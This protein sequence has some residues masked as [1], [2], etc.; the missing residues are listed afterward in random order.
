MAKNALTYY[1]YY[2]CI[3]S[4]KLMYYV[5]NSIIVILYSNTYAIKIVHNIFEKEDHEVILSPY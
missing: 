1:Q 4:V 5:T 3:P 2:S